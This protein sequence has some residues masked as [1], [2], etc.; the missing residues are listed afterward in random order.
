MPPTR[1]GSTPRRISGNA[2]ASS[3]SKRDEILRTATAYFGENGYEATKL[4]DVAAAVGIGST[5]LYHYFE[6]KLHCLYVIMAD[7]LEFFR[8]EFDRET[9]AHD[10]YLDALLAVLTS[11]YDLSEQDVMRNRVLVAEQGLVGVPR[12]SPR[13]EEARTMARARIRDVEFAW[14]TFLVRGMEQGILPEADP[15]LLT[16]ALLGLYNSIWHWYRPRGS[17]S[18]EE[19]KEFFLRRQLAVL[20]LPPGLADGD[21]SL[22]PAVVRNAASGTRGTRGARASRGRRRSAG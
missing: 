14:A 16:R 1:S 13:E 3:R 5:A 18:L 20:G 2:G 10:D 7:A 9:S 11:S 12:T 15:R 8:S 22:R 19:V 6:S 21:R 17:V 4:A